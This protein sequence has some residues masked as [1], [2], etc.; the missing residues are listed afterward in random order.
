[1]GSL[2]IATSRQVAIDRLIQVM[3]ATYADKL[4]DIQDVGLHLPAPQEAAYYYASIPAS[5]IQTNR[6]PAVF[7]YPVD[8]RVL[9][10]RSSNGPMGHFEFRTFQLMVL[11]GFKAGAGAQIERNGKTLTTD[12]LMWLRAE[13]YTGAMAHVITEYA[14]GD[15]SIH[16]IDLVDDMTDVVPFEDSKLMGI[17]ATTWQITQKILMP[18]SKPLPTP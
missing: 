3:Q 10:S 1:M 17:A 18:R 5:D 11:L 12:D 15:D 13:R 4:A 16:H 7:V 2:P 14:C 8:R 9:E 6:N